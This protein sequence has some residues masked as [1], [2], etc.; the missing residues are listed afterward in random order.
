MPALDYVG[1]R[2]V[3]EWIMVANMDLSDYR[4][5]CIGKII[6]KDLRLVAS[7]LYQMGVTRPWTRHVPCRYRELALGHG[8][9]TDLQRTMEE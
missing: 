5:R 9:W 4:C 1:L 7:R 8:R 2:T 6:A 3:I